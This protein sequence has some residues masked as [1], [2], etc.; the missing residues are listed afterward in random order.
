VSDDALREPAAAPPT[1]D[2]AE[3]L[4]RAEETLAAI[5]A[6]RVDAFVVRTASGERVVLTDR[7]VEQPY[8]VLVDGMSEGAGTLAAGGML[9]YANQRLADTLGRPRDA[10]RGASLLD[11]LEGPVPEPLHT[12]LTGAAAWAGEVAIRD[13]HGDRFE[14]HLTLARLVLEGGPAVLSMLLRDLRERRRTDAIVAAGQLARRIFD[15]ASEAIVVCDADGTVQQANREAVELCGADPTGRA[16][17]D[18]FDL[19]A[20][21][22]EAGV[23]E[24]RRGPV[25]RLRVRL[26]R[27]GGVRGLVVSAAELTDGDA[28]IVGSVVTLTDV[29]DLDVAT[30]RLEDH[31]RR[32]TAI[33]RLTRDALEGLPLDR[34]VDRARSV[35]GEHLD[36]VVVRAWGTFAVGL[37]AAPDAVPHEGVAR[38]ELRAH[39]TV[40]GWLEVDPGPARTLAADDA[41]F[42]DGVVSVL[43]MAAE[44]RLLHERLHH[45]A[46]HDALTGLP[47]RVLLEDRLRQAMA[48]A[49]RDGTMIAVLFIDLDRFKYVNDTLGHQAGNDVLVQIGDRLRRHVRGTDTVARVGGDEFVVLH[50]DL[51]DV[52]A[53]ESV[54][55]AVAELLARPITVGGRTVRVRATVGISTFPGDGEDVDALLTKSDSAMYHGKRGGRN[56][57]RVYHQHMSDAAAARLA[58]EHD[59]E[60]ALMSGELELFFQPQVSP[61]SGTISGLEA[62]TRWRHPL[63]GW[64]PPHRFVPLAEEAGLLGDLGNW[65][66][67]EACRRA[68]AWA[69]DA[70]LQRVSVNVSPAHIARPGF[71]EAVR[72]ALTAY[73]LPP[74]RLEIE[75]T[76]GIL[77][78]DLASVVRPLGALRELGV[79]IALDDFG[80]GYASFSSLGSLPLDRLKVDKSLIDTRSGAY[81]SRENQ[82][83]VLLGIT[84]MAKALGLW[85][86]IEGV[87]TVEELEMAR[88]VGCDEVQGYL[89]GGP[90][91]AAGVTKLLA[92]GPIRPWVSGDGAV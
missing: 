44:Q 2:A 34:L 9:L 75:I 33:G 14:A 7:H 57:I 29:T 78:D 89:F 10:I 48:R 77:M 39:D 90:Q 71:F 41:G 5:A 60:A 80:L 73:A 3:R 66:I 12:A 35:L 21:D 67:G 1:E 30:R 38:R 86:T 82:L 79:S 17:A 84:T 64:I 28:R 49:H 68:K 55:G 42:L 72:G 76:E 63:H 43:C 74:D 13:A 83:A 65:A 69:S 25:H 45:E 32:Q 58:I 52:G 59:F 37:A 31:I 92:G 56:T 20:M 6:N 51:R 24:L 70:W 23:H 36:D 15:T 27:G 8:R 81:G 85:V 47:N 19:A 46:H 40:L 62:L 91:P 18:A 26:R 88:G 16:F 11:F 22:G 4:R 53:A 54:A 50:G 87:E 61:L